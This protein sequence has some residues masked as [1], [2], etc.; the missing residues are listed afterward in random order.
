MKEEVLRA[1]VSV[2][3]FENG[4]EELFWQSY[5]VLDK[6]YWEK[7]YLVLEKF[8]LRKITEKVLYKTHGIATL[9]NN[10]EVSARVI[11]RLIE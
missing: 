3:G 11:Q 5:L 7:S 10:N 8:L 2:A 9:F 1:E 4:P 6:S